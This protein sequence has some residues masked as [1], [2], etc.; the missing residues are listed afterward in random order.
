MFYGCLEHGLEITIEA[1]MKTRAVGRRFLLFY[2]P[3][4]NSWTV[5]CTG[6]PWW[7]RLYKSDRRPNCT[8]QIRPSADFFSL[9]R[10]G[11][12]SRAAPAY[13]YQFL[14]KEYTFLLLY[15]KCI[16]KLIIS[17]KSIEIRFLEKSNSNNH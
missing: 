11:P 14:N 15:D 3:N 17:I 10:N 8:I 7:S 5:I 6:S 16:K 9:G 13:L 2:G 12:P 1:T 4:F